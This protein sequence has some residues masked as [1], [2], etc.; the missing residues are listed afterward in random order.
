MSAEFLSLDLRASPAA[1]EVIERLYKLFTELDAK[2]VVALR[3]GN[4]T[5]KVAISVEERES[6]PI[7]MRRDVQVRSSS[8]DRFDLTC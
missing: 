2:G 5:G 4:T 8:P 6:H 3:L 1:T 7:V